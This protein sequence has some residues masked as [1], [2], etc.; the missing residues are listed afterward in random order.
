MYIHRITKQWSNFGRWPCIKADLHFCVFRLASL[1]RKH[2]VNFCIH[3]WFPTCGSHYFRFFYRC[4]HFYEMIFSVSW[5]FKIILTLHRRRSQV[6]W[7][8][9]K[10]EKHWHVPWQ[11]YSRTVSLGICMNRLLPKIQYIILKHRIK[12]PIKF[13]IN[14]SNSC[15]IFIYS[16][17]H[18]FYS[19]AN[20]FKIFIKINL[21]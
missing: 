4:C 5:F 8:S 14:F 10:V 9:K 19:R 1:Q 2:S 15:Y 6:I 13:G 20:R 16:Y 17:I 21:N 7:T 18:K 12:L 3:Q 11:L